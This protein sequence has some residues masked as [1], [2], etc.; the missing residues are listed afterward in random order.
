M[1][2]PTLIALLVTAAS[3]AA[4]A[5]PPP[6]ASTGAMLFA[7]DFNRA[8]LG[9]TWQA[10]W[11]KITLADGALHAAQEV[12]G[13]GAVA[14]TK[15]ALR[16]GIM[17]FRFRLGEGSVITAVWNDR[18][19]KESHG[20][21]L[22]RV[23]L[24]RGQLRLGDDKE[25][26]RHEIVEMKKDP[27]RKAEVAKL[28]AG[29]IVAV[30]APIETGRWHRLA[31][32]L[33]GDEMRVTLDDQPAGYLKS[34]G[35]AHPTKKDFHFTFTG[36]D[37]AV[38]DVTVWTALPVGANTAVVPAPRDAIDGRFGGAVFLQ[39]HR[40]F[41]EEA[42]R[43]P[44]CDVLFL[45][46]SITDMWRDEERNG[47]VRGKKV[48]DKYFA[49]LHALNFA[50]GGDRTQHVLWRIQEGE[51]DRLRPKV[52][53]LL[54]GSNNTGFEREAGKAGRPRNQTPEV[55]AG[56]KA[57]VAA[58]R[59]KRPESKILLL[60]IFPRG[61]QPDLPQRRQIREANA[62]LSSLHDG[63]HVHFLDIGEK[64]LKPDGAISRALVPDA[65]HPNDKGYEVWAKAIEEPLKALLQ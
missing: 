57:V 31:I 62:A 53:V 55:I 1:K 34:S 35:L 38:D 30:P 19:Y 60:G 6:I 22:C 9:A 28:T 25:S 2:T 10:V 17:E 29:R 13:H 50:I 12:A 40:E 65:T 8:E 27:A 24:S 23:G 42:A 52:I 37:A 15:V 58:L 43:T 47:V 44:R 4:A 61:E 63:K 36:K 49:P 3:A 59:A 14:R 20:G 45:G 46:D 51:L 16:D 56:V 7:D 5:V 39:R 48:W 33:F 32:E 41:L 64:F 54:I 26:L 11:P 21:H 18:D